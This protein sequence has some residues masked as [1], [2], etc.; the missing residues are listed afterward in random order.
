VSIL[1]FHGT[2]VFNTFEGGAIISK[3]LKTKQ[4]IDHLKNF[5]FVD[6]TTVVAP[7]INGKMSEFNAALGLLQLN[8]VDSLISKREAISKRYRDFL[9]NVKGIRCL[10]L[11]SEIKYNYSY[12]PILVQPEFKITRDQLY[13]LLKAESIFARKYFFP[14]ISEFSMYRGLA[15]ALEAN[16][17][18]AT[19]A[20]RHILCLPLF[21]DLA[22]TDQMKIIDLIQNA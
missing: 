15:S 12:F 9:F 8:N 3:D 19:Q 22:L 5:G 7:G 20:S 13:D 18:I 1:S 17:P 6:E 11:Q 10:P 14:L 4:K 2:K 21:P 16:L